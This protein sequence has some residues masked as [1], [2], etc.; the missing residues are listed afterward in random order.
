MNLM[1]YF[2]IK[3]NINIDTSVT[4]GICYLGDNVKVDSVPVAPP[5]IIRAIGDPSELEYILNIK[6]GIVDQIRKYYSFQ[7]NVKEYDILTIP[8]YTKEIK[9][10]Y[11]KPVSTDEERQTGSADEAMN[12]LINQ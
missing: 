2:F 5:Y 8:R 3:N 4:T 12:W 1:K 10:K 7:V 11:T 9:Y 6:Y